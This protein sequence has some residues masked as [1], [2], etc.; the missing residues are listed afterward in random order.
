MKRPLSTTPALSSSAGLLTLSFQRAR[1]LRERFARQTLLSCLNQ[2][3][4]DSRIYRM[5]RPLG[6]PPARSGIAVS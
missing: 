6:V 5:K 2:D 4:R 1:Y 3:S